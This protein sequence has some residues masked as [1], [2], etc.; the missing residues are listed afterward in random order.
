MLLGVGR[1]SG[2]VTQL[3]RGLSGYG[4]RLTR[5]TQALYSRYL[6]WERWGSAFPYS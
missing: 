5:P 4:Y 1:V 2:S 6:I 3:N